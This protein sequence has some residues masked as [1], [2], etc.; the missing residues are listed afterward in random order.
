MSLFMNEAVYSRN[1]MNEVIESSIV[2]RV[3]IAKLKEVLGRIYLTECFGCNLQE[4]MAVIE[5]VIEIKEP[6]GSKYSDKEM[7]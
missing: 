4:T 6:N 2:K 1:Q 3:E 5:G 7:K